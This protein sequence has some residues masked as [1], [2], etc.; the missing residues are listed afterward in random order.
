MIPSRPTTICSPKRTGTGIC[1]WIRPGKSSRGRLA[2]IPTQRSSEPRSALPTALRGSGLETSS[3][4]AGTEAGT[5]RSLRDGVLGYRH[6][7]EEGSTPALEPANTELQRGEVVRRRAGR[8]GPGG[9]GYPA[10]AEAIPAW[11]GRGGGAREAGAET[12]A[13]WLL[14]RDR[15][16]PSFPSSWRLHMACGGSTLPGPT[17][18]L[19]TVGASCLGLCAPSRG[20]GVSAEWVRE[21][22]AAASGSTWKWTCRSAAEVEK[23]GGHSQAPQGLV[24]AGSGP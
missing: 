21:G 5:A 6:R 11:A 23:I 17:L 9:P 18:G 7:A 20:C 1:F 14:T 15:F 4:R 24:G 22:L 13:P 8:L 3:R 12:S 19:R 2:A 10:A 16:S